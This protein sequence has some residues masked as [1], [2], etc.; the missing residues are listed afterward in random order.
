MLHFQNFEI[1]PDVCYLD[2]ICNVWLHLGCA[3][4]ASSALSSA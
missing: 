1:L 2:L 3:D 4:L